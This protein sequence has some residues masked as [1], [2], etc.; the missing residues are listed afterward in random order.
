MHPKNVDCITT[1][2]LTTLLQAQPFS[3]KENIGRL[4]LKTNNYLASH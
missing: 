3:I 1:K 4:T 2:M